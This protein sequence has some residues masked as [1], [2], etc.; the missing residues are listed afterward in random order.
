MVAT[1]VSLAGSPTRAGASDF[2][3][4]LVGVRGTDGGLWVNLGGG[5]QGL[6][7][8]LLGAPAVARANGT[9]Y[10]VA[11]GTDHAL[12]VRGDAAGWQR[13]ST[14]PTYCSDGPAASIDGA[15]FTVACR[16][17]DDALWYAQT[18]LAAGLP[19]VG[20]LTSLGGILT[21]APAVASVEGQ[22]T[23]LVDGAA[24]RV[25][26]RTT[27]TPYSATQWSCVD[28]PALGEAGTERYFACHGSDN[29]TWFAT[30]SGGA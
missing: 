7:G 22:I 26:V 27:A 23:F 17:G 19:Q 11:V 10:Y 16:G 20:S 13:L 2:G 21:S 4:P 3:G 14:G 12:W 5:W 28:R 29:A 6:G 15:T 9:S 1:A 30:E 8:R 25:Y 18:T 24:N